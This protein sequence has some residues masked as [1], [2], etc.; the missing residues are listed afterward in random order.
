MSVSDEI[1]HA[2]MFSS[3]MIQGSTEFIMPAHWIDEGWGVIFVDGCYAVDD[4]DPKANVSDFEMRVE[5]FIYIEIIPFII[6]TR[7]EF[8]R[9][10]PKCEQRCV[11]LL[12]AAYRKCYADHTK[13]VD[14]EICVRAAYNRNK[15]QCVRKCSDCP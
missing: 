12:R 6:L 4:D 8:L 15:S 11:N 14:R 3:G 7:G 13:Q 2:E 9:G 10:N 5:D 1:K